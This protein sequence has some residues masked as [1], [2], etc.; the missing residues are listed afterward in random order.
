M[1]PDLRIAH[2]AIL[3][4]R[5]RRGLWATLGIVVLG[6]ALLAASGHA[7]A[8]FDFGSTHLDWD[9]MAGPARVVAIVCVSPMLAVL[10]GLL[11][12]ADRLLAL[13]ERG[14]VFGVENAR[15]IRRSGQLL[16]VLAV[17]RTLTGPIAAWSIERAGQPVESFSIEPEV[18]LF[19][20][21]V[22]I[23][24]VGHVMSLAADMAEE[25]SLTI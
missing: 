15:V 25:S 10:I 3:S 23:I 21:G 24:V 7:T 6:T 18:G 20:V 2:I 17:I 11:V 22:G 5:L 16:V 4:R 19:L 12:M 1:R 9:E 14:E 13:Y 8:R